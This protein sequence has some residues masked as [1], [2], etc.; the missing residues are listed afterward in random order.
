MSMSPPEETKVEVDM[1]PMIDIITLLL[2]F[3]VVVGDMA[4]SANT[5]QMKLPRA[6]QALTDKEMKEKGFRL[7]GRIVVQLQPVDK[8]H[9]EGHYSAIINNKPY[10][11]EVQGSGKQLIEYLDDQV[12]YN[13]NKGLAK[14]DSTG[15]VDMPVKLRIPE[16]APMREVERVIMSL[17][18]VG[19][20]NVHY[21]SEPFAKA[22]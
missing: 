11:L 3:L 19:M 1:V 5:I 4:A 17:A 15:A 16:D 9:P 8:T 6:D 14:K 10:A 7:E 21:A 12:N 22:K 18:K 20:V 2:M 13:V